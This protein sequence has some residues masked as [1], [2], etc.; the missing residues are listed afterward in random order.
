MAYACEFLLAVIAVFTA[1]SQI[2]GQGHLD[3]MAW[4]WKFGLGL[5]LS[6]ATVALTQA[7]ILQEKLVTRRSGLWAVVIIAFIAGMLAV[8]MYYHF[9]EPVDEN[10]EESTT[11]AAGQTLSRSNLS[12]CIL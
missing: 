12:F 3:M 9:H 5:G 1:W 6:I 2:G 10:D 8:T 7:L 11:A 4:Y